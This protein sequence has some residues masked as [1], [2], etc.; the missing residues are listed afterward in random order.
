MLDATLRRL[1]DPPLDAAGRRLAASGLSANG[2]TLGGFL[3]GLAALPMLA[4]GQFGWA[5]IV[6]LLNRLADGLDGAIARVRGVT[7]LG[8][9]LDILCDFLF[10]GAVVF[11]FALAAPENRLPGAFLLFSFIGTG[12]SFL[13]FAILAARRGRETSLRGQK[14]FYYLGGLTEGSETIALFL[15]ACLI[16][17]SFPV[18]AWVFGAACWATTLGR[19]M[20]AWRFLKG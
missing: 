17:R 9:Y 10:Y 6:I 19:A 5:L 2:V 13:A 11:G 4:A 14:S 20:A 8:G 16:P 15:L 3:L 7:D 1:I 12:S 18:L